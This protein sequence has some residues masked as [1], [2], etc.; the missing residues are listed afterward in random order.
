MNNPLNIVVQPL[1][2]PLPVG[3][4]VPAAELA[5]RQAHAGAR[6][7]LLAAACAEADELRQQAAAELGA[8]RQQAAQMLAAAR[9]RARQLHAQAQEQAVAGA[10]QWLCAEQ[11]LEQRIARELTHRWRHLTAQVLDEVLGAGEPNAR[12]LQRVERKV[13]ELLTRGR[14]TLAVAPSAMAEATRCWG[15]TPQVSVEADP[16]LAPGQARLD[17]GLVRIHLDA[18]AHQAALLEQLA[19]EPLR[20][21]HG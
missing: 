21:V 16:A 17:N 19:G 14:L 20:V 4:I 3:A 2:G 8:A 9:D 10:V 12:V 5:Q 6:E 13:A 15:A 1:P 11:D 18:P 7:T